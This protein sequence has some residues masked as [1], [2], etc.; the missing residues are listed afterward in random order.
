[1]ILPHECNSIGEVRQEIDYIDKN[2]ISL[3]GQRFSYIRE[4]VKYKNDIDAVYEK[5][6]YLN[7]I[8]IR[9]NYAADNKLDPDLIE[10]LY[11]IMLDYSINEQRELFKKKQK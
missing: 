6:R 5:E 7:V 1:M 8:R 9:R 3:I 4:I 2:I 10:D 11:R